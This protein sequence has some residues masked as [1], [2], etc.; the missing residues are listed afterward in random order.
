LLHLDGQIALS[1]G[2]HRDARA[3]FE[4]ADALA[5]TLGTDDQ[6]RVAD[7]DL[8]LL[9]LAEGHMDGALAALDAADARLDA[10][11]GRTPLGE[12]RVTFYGAR[13]EAASLR[14][15]ILLRLG[16]TADAMHAVRNARRRA[17]LSAR[18]AANLEGLDP[19]ARTRWEDAI[20]KYRQARAELESAGAHDWELAGDRL[21]SALATRKDQAARVRVLLD[22]A[23][24]LLHPHG[25]F[26]DD[27]LPPAAPGEL[28]LAYAPGMNGW[29]G[30]ANAGDAVHAARLGRLSVDSSAEELA[31]VLFSPFDDAIAHATRVRILLQGSL[32]KIDVHAL[33]WRNQPLIAHAVVEYSPDYGERPGP[34]RLSRPAAALVVADPRGD[35]PSA[36]IEAHE[37]AAALG[38]RAEWSV[39]VLDGEAASGAFTRLSLGQASLFHYA[40]HASFSGP[41]GLDSVLPLAGGSGLTAG[42][43]LALSAV[44]SY[45]FLAGCETGRDSAGGPLDVLGLTHAFLAAGTRGVISASRTVGDDL[46]RTIARE[47]YARLRADVDLAEALREAQLTVR[48]NAPDAD[49]AAFRALSP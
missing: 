28:V 26:R 1:A 22:E 15:D 24:A 49:W 34:V 23:L 31:K 46:S 43:I 40:G 21:G 41:D 11:A 6:R 44:P 45:V 12:G 5:T 10:S 13:D 35:L 32:R 18:T 20:G 42:D 39:Q 47:V 17:L 14:V 48:A 27:D 8:A 9:S 2:N 16:R 25:A 33:P 29:V 38:R 7:I 37:V 36:R 19:N 3:A 30:F 4:R